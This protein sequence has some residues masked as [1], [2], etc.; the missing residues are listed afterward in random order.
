MGGAVDCEADGPARDYDVVYFRKTI[1]LATVPARFLVDV[2]ADTRF[3][4]HVNGK[5]VGMGP[6]LGDV[7]HWRYEA[8]DPARIFTRVRTML[9]RLSGTLGRRRRLRR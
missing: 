9:R 4:L 1:S 5:R 8:F 3:E 7:H 6:A 2:S